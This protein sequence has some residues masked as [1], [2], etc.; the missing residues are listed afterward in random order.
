MI[1]S[2]RGAGFD[3][4]DNDGDIDA[5]VLNAQARPTILRNESLAANHWLDVRL[6]GVHTNRDAVGAR[7]TVVAG[8]LTQVAEVHGGRSYQGYH[9]SRLHFG[10]GSRESV[11]R[12]E[13]RWLGSGVETFENIEVDRT[14]A[15]TEGTTRGS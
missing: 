1:Q 7:V 2:S 3:D 6:R 9:G 11:D 8:D 12:M 10:L 13:V 5:V 15:L 14:L 4:L